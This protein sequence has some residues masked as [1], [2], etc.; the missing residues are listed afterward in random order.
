MSASGIGVNRA[1]RATRKP[2]V[3]AAP[4]VCDH[5]A[6]AAVRIKAHERVETEQRLELGADVPHSAHMTG[7]R[8]DIARH[9]IAA[10][11]EAHFRASRAA[12]S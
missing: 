11:D 6:G 3:D 9:L 4:M 10:M 2:F 8:D 12:R 5:A 7:E 1:S